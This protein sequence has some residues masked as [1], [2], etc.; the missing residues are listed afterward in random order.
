MLKRINFN[1][2]RIIMIFLKVLRMEIGN[3]AA[4]NPNHGV[5]IHKKH[6][7]YKAC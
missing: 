3:L 2:N 4:A 7:F 5:T 6:T 1:A